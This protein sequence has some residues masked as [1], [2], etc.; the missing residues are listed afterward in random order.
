MNM[1]HTALRDKSALAVL[2]LVRV[3][4]QEVGWE[5]SKIVL[6]NHFALTLHGH[7]YTQAIAIIIHL[8]AKHTTPQQNYRPLGL[9]EPLGHGLPV[10]DVPDGAEVLGLAILVLQVV[11]V[12]PGVDAQQGDQVAGDGVL[13]GAGDQAQGAGL[14]VL[15]D[16][17]PAAALDA[18]EGGVCLLHEGGEGAE[19]AVDRFLWARWHVSLLLLWRSCHTLGCPR[20][21]AQVPRSRAIQDYLYLVSTYLELSF[22]LTTT[23]LVGGCQVLPEQS[24]VD[25]STA[26]EVEEGRECGG[27]GRVALGYGIAKGLESAVEAVDVGL[28][29]LG[30]VQLHDLARD[31]RLECAIVVCRE[32]SQISILVLKQRISSVAKADDPEGKRAGMSTY[33]KGR[34][35]WPCRGRTACWPCP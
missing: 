27:L 7:D 35:E 25:V 9:G 23:V 11:G 4:D 20:R 17:G 10:D 19:V 14:L 16:P 22:W 34:E 21:A 29:V 26:V 5:K 31:V 24:V 33:R 2:P 6:E 1:G 3:D 12:L 15:G 13:V 18:G 28:V 32:R 8:N 30:V